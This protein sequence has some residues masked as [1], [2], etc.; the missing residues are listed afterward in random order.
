[1][2]RGTSLVS[3]E[4]LAEHINAPDVRVVDGSWYLPNEERDPHAEY[5]ERHIHGAV[6]FDIDEISNEKSALPHMLPSP[7]KFSSR[8]RKLGLGDG[9][10]IV[11]YDG[12]N[13][14]AAARVWWMF[15][16]FGHED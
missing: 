10:R 14:M 15:R 16:A 11:I 3:T 2:Q 13:M 5:A 9:V 8:A 12:G 1:M 7:E 6:F 4:W